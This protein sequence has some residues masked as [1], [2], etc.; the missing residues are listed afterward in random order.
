MLDIVATLHPSTGMVR[1]WQIFPPGNA[2]LWLVAVDVGLSEVRR[3]EIGDEISFD[4]V[5]ATGWSRQD[6]MLRAAGEAVERFSLI[7]RDPDPLI[8]QSQ[9]VE[10]PT[11]LSQFGL[12]N[13]VV[14]NSEFESAK[15]VEPLMENFDS[16]EVNRGCL[17]GSNWFV[18]VALITDP[19]S[20]R[21]A[22]DSSPSG[23]ASGPSWT[24]ATGRALMESIERDAALCC[25]ALRPQIAFYDSLTLASY[26]E[27]L[28]A[29][30]TED[31]REYLDRHNLRA[32]TTLISSE[33][34]GIT[35]SV[36]F[37]DGYHADSP[38]L[39]TGARAGTS[40]RECVSSSL[41]EAIQ[42]H[43]ALME[44]ADQ[45]RPTSR[46][47]LVVNEMDRAWYCLSSTARDHYIGW[48]KKGE[49]TDN[50]DFAYLSQTEV[51][52]PSI[53]ELFIAL[54]REGLRPLVA[55]LTERLP[56]AIRADGWC[57]VRAIVLGHQ[58]YRMDDTKK[59]TWLVARLDEW[60]VRLAI[61]EDVDVRDTPP[62]PL[63]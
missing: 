24:F 45:P 21:T 54:R 49:R 1:G 34:P 53:S 56:A 32:R 41:R 62:H 35:I 48:L 52:E 18:P 15:I 60:R 47:G 37:L 33:I 23:A 2:P 9:L 57:A 59:W 5:G 61:G 55:D 12:L 16:E 3:S 25:W 50:W 39:A 44:L 11:G 8:T 7:S 19:T 17:S 28:P 38:V 22:F 30:I 14:C 58:P 20:D 29:K 36:A 42:V 31:V 6:A 4:L 27:A 40:L 26:L 63:I 43:S 10:N 46:S 51:P 13:P